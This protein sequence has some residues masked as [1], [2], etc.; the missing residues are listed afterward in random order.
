MNNPRSALELRGDA[1][2]DLQAGSVG[3]MRSGGGRIALFK[4]EQLSWGGRCGVRQT[5]P[6][7]GKW[8]RYV[9]LSEIGFPG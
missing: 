5:I 1:V 4:W 9:L 6:R 7:V 2:E 8:Q 3:W